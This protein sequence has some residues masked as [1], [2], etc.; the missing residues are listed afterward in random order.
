[1]KYMS[2]DCKV[3]VFRSYMQ[4]GSKRS[5]RKLLEHLRSVFVDAR[6]EELYAKSG[7]ELPMH[8]RMLSV[9]Q[10]LSCVGHSIGIA[11]ACFDMFR[12]GGGRWRW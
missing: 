11:M 2:H 5:A 9:Q 10:L 6:L 1:M 7:D 12:S 4:R 3:Y 8:V